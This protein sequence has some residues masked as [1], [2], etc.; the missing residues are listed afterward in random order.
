MKRYSIKDLLEQK[1]KNKWK[2]FRKK[3][4]VLKELETNFWE[5]AVKQFSTKIPCNNIWKEIPKDLQEKICK[6][7]FELKIHYNDYNK[8]LKWLSEFT[9]R[10]S[11]Y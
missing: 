10:R 1:C 4:W 9:P 8:N 3:H 7:L 6:T 2:F 5:K 11:G